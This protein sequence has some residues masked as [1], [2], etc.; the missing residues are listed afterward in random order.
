MPGDVTIVRFADDA[1]L[2]FQHE[3]Q[4][5]Q[6]LT[7]LQARLTEFGLE[8]NAEKTRLIRFG[9][10]ARLNR[11]ERGKGNRRRSPSWASST[12]V[13]GRAWGDL[14]SG[15]SRTALDGGRNCGNLSRSYA[16]ECT[17]RSP[18]RANG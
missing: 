1:I 18:R 4:A 3:A 9:R 12:S 6:Y 15:A 2:G 16:G 8:L 5:R 7:A 10:F 14:K 17:H 13:R 11:E